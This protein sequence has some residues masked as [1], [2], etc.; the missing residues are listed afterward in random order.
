MVGVLRESLKNYMN[1]NSIDKKKLQQHNDHMK[2]R[3]ITTLL[4]TLSTFTLL[5]CLGEEKETD[6]TDTEIGI[7]SQ[8]VEDQSTPVVEESSTDTQPVE[9]AEEPEESSFIIP[10]LDNPNPALGF[11]TEDVVYLDHTAIPAYENLVEEN[12]WEAP[13]YFLETGAETYLT[14]NEYHN[15]FALVDWQNQEGELIVQLEGQDGTIY[16]QI[17]LEEELES[18]SISVDEYGFEYDPPV[19]FFYYSIPATYPMWPWTIRILNNG[20]ILGEE[21]CSLTNQASLLKDPETSIFDFDW[22]WQNSFKQGDQF[23]LAFYGPLDYSEVVFFRYDNFN[24]ELM[25]ETYIPELAFRA[26]PKNNNHY[27]LTFTIGEEFP[28]GSYSVFID[29]VNVLHFQVHR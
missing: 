15:N 20:T 10:E 26:S 16:E 12:M 11:F 19:L 4:I 28:L 2:I 27:L 1:I 9:E 14:Y 17:I 8:N 5:S 21:S 29:G 18:Y 6:V 3:I 13:P 23:T 22:Q 7:T 24:E 25:L